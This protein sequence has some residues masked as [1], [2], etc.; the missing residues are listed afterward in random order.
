MLLATVQLVARLHQTTVATAVLTDAARSVAEAPLGDL[1]DARRAADLELARL[2]GGDADVAW[3]LDDD[4][5]AIE[6]R[7]HDLVRG[8]VVRRE[9][10]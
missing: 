4:T 10:P 7:L 9:H 3:R 5:V 8:A 6:V 2:L 1:D